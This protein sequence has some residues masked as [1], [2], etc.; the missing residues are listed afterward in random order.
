MLETILVFALLFLILSICLWF[1]IRQ[2][3][4]KRHDII[5]P[6]KFDFDAFKAREINRR[7]IHDRTRFSNK[8]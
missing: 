8:H 7:G 6:G 5:A 1:F 2:S 4:R 3:V